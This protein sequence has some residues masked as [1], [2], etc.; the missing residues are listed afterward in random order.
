M[1]SK[2][3]SSHR[4]ISFPQNCEVHSLI[5]QGDSI[6]TRAATKHF[7]PVSTHCCTHLHTSTNQKL[8]MKLNISEHNPSLYKV[9]EGPLSDRQWQ[10][11]DRTGSYQNSHF[12]SVW[13]F[14]QN[15]RCLRKI[16]GK[17]KYGQYCPKSQKC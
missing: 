16:F 5:A 11:Y 9:P 12:Q 15:S 1:Y 7:S 2:P 17:L 3:D 8:C 14:I 10:N 4:S 13:E 6:I